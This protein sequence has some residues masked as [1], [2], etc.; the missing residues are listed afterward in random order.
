[1][2]ID[3]EGADITGAESE[4]WRP[5]DKALYWRYSAWGSPMPLI[6]LNYGNKIIVYIIFCL[7]CVVFCTCLL[8]AAGISNVN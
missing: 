5:R 7:L 4:G 1:M 3:G 2:V 6:G 8:C